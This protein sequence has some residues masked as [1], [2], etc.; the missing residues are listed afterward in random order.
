VKPGARKYKKP[1]LH[2]RGGER[3]IRKTR[4]VASQPNAPVCPVYRV[5]NSH[6]KETKR[7]EANLERLKDRNNVLSER[8]PEEGKHTGK[9]RIKRGY[10]LPLRGGLQTHQKQRRKWCVLRPNLYGIRGGENEGERDA[11]EKRF[12]IKSSDLYC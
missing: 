1:F 8:K 9:K 11:A 12:L 10:H 3:T 5:I 7:E 4:G 6:W 2:E